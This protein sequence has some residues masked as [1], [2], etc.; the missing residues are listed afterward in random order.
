MPKKHE[1][2]HPC[3]QNYKQQ[4]KN[5]SNND[6]SHNQKFQNKLFKEYQRNDMDDYIRRKKSVSSDMT[7]SQE[8]LQWWAESSI[9]LKSVPENNWINYRTTIDPLNGFMFSPSIENMR[10]RL[11]YP[12]NVQSHQWQT[13]RY[14]S[15]QIQIPPIARNF[16][17]DGEQFL[18]SPSQFD[19][20]RSFLISSVIIHEFNF[21]DYDDL[22]DE[23]YMQQ[24]VDQLY[25]PDQHMLVLPGR[26]TF[27]WNKKET[28]A[29]CQE[30][31]PGRW[32]KLPVCAHPFHRKCIVQYVSHS[33]HPNCPVCRSACIQ[34]Y[35]KI[36]SSNQ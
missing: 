22:S 16:D 5:I 35:C 10:R 28:C 13:L 24:F 19:E 4:Y 33:R 20:F 3:L 34:T 6:R 1:R 27:K 30:S 11:M 9:E 8:I 26:Y 31:S 2:Q 25:K 32:C 15:H 14:S 21:D 36:N 29:I 23:D 12:E 18:L 17:Y 7:T